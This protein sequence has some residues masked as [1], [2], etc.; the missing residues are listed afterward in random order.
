MVGSHLAVHRDGPQDDDCEVDDGAED[1][2]PDV[3]DEHGAFYKQDEHGEDGD[4]DIEVC[5]SALCVSIYFSFS[6]GLDKVFGE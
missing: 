6:F 2:V 5:Q 4:G 3:E 1:G